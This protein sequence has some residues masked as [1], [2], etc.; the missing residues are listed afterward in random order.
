MNRKDLYHSFHE[1]DDDILERS[2]SVTQRKRRPVWL[3]LGTLAACLCLMVIVAIPVLNSM[4]VQ[5][6]KDPILEIA[7]LEYDGRFY[8]AVDIPKVL[9]KYG[10]PSKITADMAGDHLA[11]LKSNG[12]VCYEY[13]PFETNIELYQYAP[14]VCDGVYVLRDDNNWYAALFYNFC[15]Y[16]SNTKH[17]FTELYHVYDVR[18]ADD[19]SS[20]TEMDWNN[21]REVGAA[22]IDHQEI[23]EFYDMTISLQSYGNDDFQKIMFDGIPEEEQPK[24]HNAFADDYRSIRIKTINGLSFYI[25]FHPSFDWIW[26]TGTM[27]YY[28]IDEQM[29]AWIDRNLD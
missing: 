24:A 26:G 17:E 23:K 2:E 7:T 18:S 3:K 4:Y 19:I 1:V 13:T 5:D 10:L 6:S 27:S 16:D 8:E 14:A 21:D 12:G 29:H 11:Y 20:I 22:V 15:Q 9:E 28:Q 25:G